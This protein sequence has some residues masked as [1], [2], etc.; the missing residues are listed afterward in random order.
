MIPDRY[1]I[2]LA[3]LTLVVAAATGVAVI[4]GPTSLQAIAAP[5]AFADCNTITEPGEY[6]L[7]GDIENGG[8]DN[9]TYISGSCIRIESSDVVLEGNGHAVDGF[10]VSDTTAIT[11][12]GAGAVENVTVRNLETGDWNRGIYMANV[13]NGTVEYAAVGGNSY[14][15]FV[16]DSRNVT[17]ENVSAGRYFV[18]VYLQNTTATL[19]NNTLA[20]DHV[21]VL[22]NG[23]EVRA[24]ESVDVTETTPTA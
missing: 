8:D 17:V 13:T 4:V 11:V 19:A 15:V 3:V 16:Q 5:N 22:A 20:G 1:R 23:S 12:G 14:G 2:P 9:F 7:V 18:G 21:D 10:G 6:R 24:D